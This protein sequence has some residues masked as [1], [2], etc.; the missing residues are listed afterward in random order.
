MDGMR[1]IS[2]PVSYAESDLEKL[3]TNKPQSLE[4]EKERLR[5]ATAEFESL[6]MYQMLKAMRKTIGENPLAHDGPMTSGMG[7]DTFMDM[8]DVHLAK[9]MVTGGK[10]SIADVL[11]SSLVRTIESRYD[12]EASRIEIKPLQ[13]P[14]E[15]REPIEIQRHDLPVERPGSRPVPLDKSAEAPVRIAPRRRAVT[16]PQDGIRRRYG[17]LI[18][19]A[20]KANKVDSA[21]ISAVIQTESGGDPKAVSP[22]GAKGLMQ[23]MDGTAADLGVNNSFDERE[24]VMSGAR[25]LR[26]MVDRFGDLKLALAAYNA[27]P[28]AVERH[29]G[30]PPY[31]E[32]QA[33]VE[34]VLDSLEYY[35]GSVSHEMSKGGTTPDR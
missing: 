35:R 9:K 5:K 2:T 26:R 20:A 10:G 18:D 33:Y 14:E 25:Y 30:I 21:L 12:P 19:E 16:R 32:T 17:Q 1:P 23:L 7:K 8:F 22:A 15:N 13:R 34:R 6:F 28:G 31:P 24:N 27:G 3:R 11:Y 4:E 29:G